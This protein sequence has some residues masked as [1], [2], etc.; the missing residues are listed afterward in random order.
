VSTEEEALRRA[1]DLLARLEVARARLEAT[2]D[3]DEAIA[4]LQELAE[5]AREVE[6]ELGRARAAAD[7]NADAEDA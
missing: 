3:P 7:A 6:A 4:V 1:E 5:L 2:D